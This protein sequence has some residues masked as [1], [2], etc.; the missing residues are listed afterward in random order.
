[1]LH[2]HIAWEAGFVGSKLKPKFDIPFVLT[3]H[4]GD[5]QTVPEIG[6]GLCLK[7][8][9]RA[10]VQTALHTADRV[11]AVSQRIM[12]AVTNLGCDPNRVRLIHPGTEYDSIQ[13]VETDDLRP[14]LGWRNGDFIVLS[15]GR[16]SPVK[17]MPTLLKAVQ[18][19][20][21]EIPN[22]RCLMVG[23]DESLR[24]MA[25]DM[26]LT[27]RVRLLGRIPSNYDPARPSSTILQTPYAE[28]IAAYRACDVFVSTSYMESFNTAAL[29][30]FSCGKPVIV[31]NTQGF[32]DVL[33]EGINGYSVPPHDPDALA[34]KLVELAGNGELRTRM[35]QAA[36]QAAKNYDWSKVAQRFLT[37]YEEAVALCSGSI[38]ND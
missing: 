15:V 28:M 20:A 6:Y 5:V 36:Q 33:S 30:A 35:G 17:D 1:V 26:Q 16:N 18:I 31:T 37:V 11:T 3:P 13:R 10:K 21:R 12:R 25:G 34:R 19:A 14:K 38:T 4:G 23:P 32:T 22:I 2:A 24:N 27:E 8:E 7:P 9:L 29:D